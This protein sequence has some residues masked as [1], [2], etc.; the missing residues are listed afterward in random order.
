MTARTIEAMAA[1][2]LPMTEAAPWGSA[3]AEILTGMSKDD[4]LNENT[5]THRDRDHDRAPALALVQS[6][7]LAPAP[8]LSCQQAPE[9]RAESLHQWPGTWEAEMR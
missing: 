1:R 5:S 4:L 3:W 2:L 8:P 7:A 6:P 9:E